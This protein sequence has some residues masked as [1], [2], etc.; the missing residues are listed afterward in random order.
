MTQKKS[1]IIDAFKKFARRFTELGGSSGKMN[2]SNA[3]IENFK[4][5]E[6]YIRSLCTDNAKE[7]EHLKRMLGAGFE[8]NYAPLCSRTKR[9]S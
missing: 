4:D 2:V 3:S 5:V 8:K 9:C 1:D 6:V 7:Y